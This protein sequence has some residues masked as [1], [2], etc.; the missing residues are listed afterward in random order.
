MKDV[1]YDVLAERIER[2]ELGFHEWL[3][4]RELARIHAFVNTL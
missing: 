4:A 2:R 3:R 1:N